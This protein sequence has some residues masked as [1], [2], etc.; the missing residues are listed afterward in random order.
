MNVII[1]HPVCQDN[2]PGRIYT[3]PA[4][5]PLNGIQGALCCNAI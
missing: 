1:E 3:Y 4:K 5:S 2:A